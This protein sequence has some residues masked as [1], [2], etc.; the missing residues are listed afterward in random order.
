[1]TTFADVETAK[2]AKEV[3]DGADIYSGCCTL[4]IEFAKVGFSNVAVYFII[5]SLRKKYFRWCDT[6][7]I[8]YSTI[9]V[10][11]QVHN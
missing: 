7:S 9:A 10:N 2:R 8:N 6:L 1:M 5:D 11:F 4:K 3:L